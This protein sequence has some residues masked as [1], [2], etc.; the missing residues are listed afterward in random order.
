MTVTKSNFSE[1]FFQQISISFP[2]CPR[3]T[4]RGAAA[5]Y[6]LI[7]SHAASPRLDRAIPAAPSSLRSCISD[8][9]RDS[10]SCYY[11]VDL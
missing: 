3:L 7:L 1:T 10:L 4:P 6:D 2:K 8:S 5:A 9:F 11:F